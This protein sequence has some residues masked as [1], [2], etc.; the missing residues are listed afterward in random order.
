MVATSMVRI[1]RLWW[2]WIA[3]RHPSWLTDEQLALLSRWTTEFRAALVRKY[4]G[5]F[6]RQGGPANNRTSP[7]S[8]PGCSRF[9]SP[10]VT[11]CMRGW[12]GLSESRPSPKPKP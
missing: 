2:L 7:T 8:I 1:A 4:V 3:R 9:A 11:R 12:R 10:W 5:N 6:E